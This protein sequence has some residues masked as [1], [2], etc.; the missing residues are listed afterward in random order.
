MLD[1]GNHGRSDWIAAGA[2]TCTSAEDEKF[3]SFDYM[4]QSSWLEVTQSDL[5]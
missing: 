4:N 3:K 1:R 2:S 5:L